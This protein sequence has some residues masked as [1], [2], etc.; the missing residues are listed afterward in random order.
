MVKK[1]MSVHIID[2]ESIDD[3]LPSPEILNS[4]WREIKSVLRGFWEGMEASQNINGNRFQVLA[5]P[6]VDFIAA[7]NRNAAKPP[8]AALNLLK[9]LMEQNK[10]PSLNK[11]RYKRPF[12]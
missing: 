8:E 4:F 10:H 5:N 6:Y 11:S 2:F 1:D 9:D 7:I 3:N 12:I